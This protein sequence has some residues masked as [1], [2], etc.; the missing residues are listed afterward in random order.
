LPLTR[1][2]F[3]VC[4]PPALVVAGMLGYYLIERWPLF[5]CLYMSAI[6]L[7]T[8]GYMEVHPLSQA[9]RLFTIAFS[10]GGIFSIFY[11]AT[12][13]IRA[14]VGGEL[15]NALG[16]Q[17]MERNLSHLHQHYIV[18]GL[19][20]VGRLVCQEFEAGRLPFVA[21]DR[22]PAQLEGFA[23]SHGIPLQGDA[24]LDEVLLHAGVQRA[25]GLIAI[26]AS[27]A[28]NL[29]ITMSAR[30]LN[31]K[32][33][34]VARAEGEGADKKL[35][36]AGANRVVSPYIIGGMRV[37]HAMLRPTVVDFIELATRTGHLELQLE[38]VRVAP[39]SPLVGATLQ[40]QCSRQKLG[41]IIVSIKKP[42]GQ[43]LFN[44]PPETA[45]QANDILIA[46]GDRGQLD[47]LESL[48]RP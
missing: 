17:L 25:R 11:S 21:I 37:A 18:C 45:L 2:V 35:L 1:F 31:D 33:F 10:L 28:D 13:V 39:G 34:I 36:R 5:D 15:Q 7:T 8:V 20:R 12:A 6:T 46:L 3:A 27:D 26:V 40:D 29:F 24:T 48:A 30:L 23:F 9:G 38:E 41:L 16:K 22:N 44:P 14:I 19:G 32:L 43:M 4:L 42:S 47:R